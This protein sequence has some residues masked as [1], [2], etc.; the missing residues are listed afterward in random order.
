[1]ESPGQNEASHEAEKE[2]KS[3]GLRYS[4]GDLHNY[5]VP[6]YLNE[7]DKQVVMQFNNDVIRSDNTTVRNVNSRDLGQIYLKTPHSNDGSLLGLF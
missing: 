2:R 4:V 1:M 7:Q 5:E 3:K 6:T